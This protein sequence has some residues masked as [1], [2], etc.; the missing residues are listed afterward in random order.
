M[1]ISRRQSRGNFRAELTTKTAM[2]SW[3]QMSTLHRLKGQHSQDIFYRTKIS[4]I[5]ILEAVNPS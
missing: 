2:I 5:H 4:L 1:S 3:A